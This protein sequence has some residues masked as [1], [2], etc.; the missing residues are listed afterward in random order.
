MISTAQLNNYLCW[1]DERGQRPL[2]GAC[3]F[4]GY[5]PSNASSY[6]VCWDNLDTAEQP[7]LA[8]GMAQLRGFQATHIFLC[9]QQGGDLC[10][11]QERDLQKATAIVLMGKGVARILG[12]E[13]R[14]ALQQGKIFHIP[15]WKNVS[16]L[17]TFHPRDIHRYPPNASVWQRDL[18][19]ARSIT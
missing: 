19:I 10:A 3:P 1:L 8:Q 12:G 9:P 14:F 17:L 16:F 4:C 18:S 15:H 7:L 13:Q 2:A 5:R 6:L 11:R